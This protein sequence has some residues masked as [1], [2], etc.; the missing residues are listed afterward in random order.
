MHPLNR[1]QVQIYAA[2]RI[3]V[4][5]LFACHG[6]EKLW[7]IASGDS[8]LQAAFLY[9]A[10]G[11]ESVGG[12]LITLG[13]FTSWTALICSGQM[14]VGY[15]VFHQPTG[16]IPLLNGGE[17]AVLFC[18]IFLLIAARG[19]GIWSLDALRESGTAEAS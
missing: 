14:A 19:A 16:L 8:A 10:A 18:W 9:P 11:I 15:F 7:G 12:V 13:L 4:G 2:T 5:F 17:L 6:A 3:V 1:Y